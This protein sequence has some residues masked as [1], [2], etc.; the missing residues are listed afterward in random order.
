MS[1]INGVIVLDKPQSFTSLDAVAV[2]RRLSGQRKIGHTGTLDPMATGVLPLLLGRATR[3]GSLLEDTDKEYT[4]GFALGYETDTEDST[5]RETARNDV[6]VSREALEALL[7]RFRG[8][9]LQVPPMYSAVQKDGRRLYDLARKGITV[10][11]EP[12]PVTIWKLILNE[13]D[14]VS[15]TGSLTVACSKG[16]YIRTLCADIGKALGT[17]GVMTSLRRTRACGFTLEDAV[18]LEDARALSERGE[19]PTA[20]RPV[21]QLFLHCPQLEVSAAQAHRFRNGGALG[22]ERT[23]LAGKAP[24]EGAQYRVY[25]PGKEFLGLGKVSGADLA[26]LRLFC[27]QEE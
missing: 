17:Y 2:M 15:R 14:E 18:T 3:A 4:A 20:V 12:R 6:P 26:V 7:P 16:T 27:G 1:E 19:F 25:S 24:A 5:G 11:R 9:I 13:Y 21:E 22:L 10:E 8:E 23:K